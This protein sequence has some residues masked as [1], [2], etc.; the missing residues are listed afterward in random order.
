MSSSNKMFIIA[1]SAV[2]A[3][4]ITILA[5]GS[6]ISAA[7]YGNAIEQRLEAK[8]KDNENVY[9][10]YGQKIAEV[11]QIPS[12]Y[13]DDLLK[14]TTAAI[15]GRYGTNGTQSTMIW[16]KEQNPSLDPAM[17]NKIIQLIESG[18]DEFKNA[19]TGMLDIKR[20]YK[21]SLGTIWKGFWL[22]R[23]GYPKLDLDEYDIVTTDDA[24]T[25]FKTKREQ[26]LILRPTN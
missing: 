3:A 7:N 2:L 16:I 17:H 11:S 19:Q 4:A 9:A 13:T 20:S 12:M 25:A 14:L 15:Q 5:T 23:A 22:K 21:A 26:K 24:S 8:Q 1:G 10:S 6:Y 18:R